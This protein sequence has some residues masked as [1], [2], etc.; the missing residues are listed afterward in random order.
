SRDRGRV[1]YQALGLKTRAQA[2][3]ALG[4]T[5]EA[6]VDLRGA[7]DLT[8]PTGDPAMF[9]QVAAALLDVEGDDALAREAYATAQRI[10]AALPNDEM[11]RIFEVAEPVQRLTKQYNE[12]PKPTAG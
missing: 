5:R 10:S 3:A 9:F 6:I 11:R 2:L 1:K 4:R 8:R 12:W 7:V